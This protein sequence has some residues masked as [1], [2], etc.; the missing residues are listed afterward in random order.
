MY[1]KAK[2]IPGIIEKKVSDSMPK[3]VSALATLC[4]NPC[5]NAKPK[6]RIGKALQSWVSI[7]VAELSST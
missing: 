6:A 2:H 5:W 3:F 4:A 1:L 7:R